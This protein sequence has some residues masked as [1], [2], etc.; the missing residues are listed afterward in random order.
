MKKIGTVLMYV[1]LAAIT[2]A[3]VYPLLWLVVNSFKEQSDLYENPWGLSQYFTL[4]NYVKALFAGK[5][6]RY[7]LNS[8]IITGVSVVFTVVL[9]VMASYGLVRL[10]WKGSGFVKNIFMT[11]M[12]IPAFSSL[13]P[14]YSMFNKMHILDSYLAVI[15]PNT[16]FALAMAVF[17]MCGFFSSLH[18][19]MEEAAII[20]GCSLPKV[21]A[22]IIFPLV[23]SGTVTITVIT[24]VTVWNDLLFSQ[25]F[26]ND[27]DK[28][29]LPFGL[30]EF[31]GQY[32]TDYVGMIAAIVIAVIPVIIIYSF[33]HD[34]IINGMTA[35]AVKG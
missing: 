34:K 5:I 23:R 25:I 4:A 26:V 19:E 8:V 18:R 17:I 9:S 28:M 1:L 33:L 7:F 22:Y 35:G 3:C 12:M 14:L 31:Q 10:K 29:P 6:G 21:F 13:I 15:I 32:G 24:F 30:T 2:I 27:R 20:D 16:T 11:G